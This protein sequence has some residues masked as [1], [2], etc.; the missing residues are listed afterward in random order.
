MNSDDGYPVSTTASSRQLDLSVPIHELPRWVW[1]L[2]GVLMFA[3]LIPYVILYG[4][5]TLLYGMNPLAI[6]L[7]F[8]GLIVLHEAIHAIGWKLASGLPWTVF[9]FGF[10]WRALAPYCHAKEPMGVNAYRIGGIL[11]LIFTGLVPWLIG[12]AQADATVTVL[13]TLLIAGAVGDIYVLWSLRHVPASAR[14]IDHESNA[15]C[16]VLL[17]ETVS[18]QTS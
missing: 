12:L 17:D 4:I 16:V 5:F 2:S 9:S 18:Y 3:P 15:G 14:V 6:L 11:P 8:M 1:M 10:A 7:G 13:G